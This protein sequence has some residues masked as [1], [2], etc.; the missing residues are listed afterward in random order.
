MVVAGMNWPPQRGLLC[1]PCCPTSTSAPNLHPSLNSDRVNALA[2]AVRIAWILQQDGRVHAP[3]ARSPQRRRKRSPRS[4][5]GFRSGRSAG[6]VQRPHPRPAP[7]S[8]GRGPVSC[9]VEGRRAR[10]RTGG[11]EKRRRSSA[12]QCQSVLRSPCRVHLF[13]HRAK[14]A[15]PSPATMPARRPDRPA[16]DAR[17]RDALR[18]P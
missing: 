4:M 7:P 6:F 17:L 9:D 1:R 8:C 18:G 16:P 11:P 13:N 2:L 15:A 12:P 3:C 10:W 14:K 5:C